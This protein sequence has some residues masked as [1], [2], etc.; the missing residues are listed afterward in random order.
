MSKDYRNYSYKPFIISAKEAHTKK[1]VQYN[2]NG[3]VVLMHPSLLSKKYIIKPQRQFPAIFASFM[4]L[5]KSLSRLA[6]SPIAVGKKSLRQHFDDEFAMYREMM[7]NQTKDSWEPD[8]GT[9]VFDIREEKLYLILPEFWHRLGLVTNTAHLVQDVEQKMSWI[10]V[11]NVL[12]SAVIG[13]AG[14]SVGGNILE[15]WMREGRPKRVKVADLDWVELTNLN[16]LERGSLQY[17]VESRALK[18]N[19]KNGYEMMRVKK[20]ELAAY[21]HH[22]V[23][24]YAQ[25]YVYSEGINPDTIEQ[26]ILGNKDEPRL[27]LMVEEM[28]NFPLKYEV[29]ELC[30]KHGIPVLMLSDFGHRIQIQLQDFR[31]NKKLPLGYNITDVELKKRLETVM[32]NGGDRQDIF[33]FVKGL[34][35]D[36]F[37]KDEFALW[38]KGEGEQPTSSLPQSGATAQA[39]GGIGGKIIALYMLGFQ[40]P[41]R[42][43]YDLRNHTITT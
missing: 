35:G 27:D 26:F 22:M 12:S 38:V 1:Y 4:D 2:A 11:K 18:R 13:F 5:N 39:A 28:D 14:V 8:Y 43:I 34:C 40:F 33:T 7:K 16:R 32:A 9:Y 21:E 42:F 31:K 30:R 25:W 17:L 29:R 3:N 20:A 15:G 6:N 37:A 10:E 41:D 23:D 24:P 36:D 19:K